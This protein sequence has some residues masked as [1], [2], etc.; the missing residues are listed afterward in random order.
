[1][2]NFLPPDHLLTP[3]VMPIARRGVAAGGAHLR[4]DVVG[5][6]SA[7]AA[8]GVRFLDLLFEGLLRVR[9]GLSSDLERERRQAKGQAGAE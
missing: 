2:L 9:H 4:L 3:L 1:M 8:H 5:G 6:A 7:A